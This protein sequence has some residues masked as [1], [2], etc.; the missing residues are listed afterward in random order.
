MNGK[1]EFLYQ[2]G[3]DRIKICCRFVQEKDFGPGDE[4]PCDCH[5]LHLPP[6]EGN[7]FPVCK[8]QETDDIERLMNT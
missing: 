1:D 3:V 6:G 5:A 4:R 8:V 2:V 7:R